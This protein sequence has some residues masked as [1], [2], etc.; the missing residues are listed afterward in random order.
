MIKRYDFKLQKSGPI[1]TRLY[2]GFKEN[3]NLFLQSVSSPQEASSSQTPSL[4]GVEIMLI[5]AYKYTCF[6]SFKIYS[7]SAHFLQCV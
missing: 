6:Y 2:I 5:L 3:T 4:L 1:P 7:E